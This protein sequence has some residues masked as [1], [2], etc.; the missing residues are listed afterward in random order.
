[1]EEAQP[2]IES[3]SIYASIV[4]LPLMNRGFLFVCILVFSRSG[5]YLKSLQYIKSNRVL[6]EGTQLFQ[7]VLNMVPSILRSLKSEGYE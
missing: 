6:L 1:M 3:H 5:K 7:N 4:L 2:L